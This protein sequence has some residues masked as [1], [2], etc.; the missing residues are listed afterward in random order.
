MNGK[1]KLFVF[2]AAVA[3]HV[4]WGFSFMFSRLALDV[5]DVILVLSHRFLLA[6]AVMSLLP[7][8]GLVKLRLRGK[9]VLPLILMGLAEPVVYFFGEQYGI[10]HSTTI[11]SG[12]MIAMIPIVSTV[13]AAPFLGE[14]PTGP[15]LLFG[16]VSVAGVVCLGLMSRSQGVLDWIGV[17][18]LLVA[19]FSACA[20]TLLCRGT[21]ERF[22][23]FERT[24]IVMGVGAAVFTVLALIRCR[25]S[26]AA[27]LRPFADRSYLLSILV[28]ALFC[29]VIAY[30]LSAYAITHL[31]VAQSTVFL[32]L[33]TAVSVF[34]GVVFLHE[35]LTWTGLAC[36]IVILVGIYGVQRCSRKKEE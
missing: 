5:A 14:R 9:P 15:Q 36:C 30:F 35:P 29:S 25:G 27:W 32:N 21:S 4:F 8:T 6:F 31:P 20:Y 23:A 33:T 13:A 24:Y 10:L 18:A 28:L 16:L 34:A 1:K 2:A 22:S 7:L 12:V 11:F 26:A 3:S 19:V 17:V